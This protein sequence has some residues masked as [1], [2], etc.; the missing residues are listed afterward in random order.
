RDGVIQGHHVVEVVGQFGGGLFE[1][2]IQAAVSFARGVGESLGELS[3]EVFADEWMS[4][5]RLEIGD[6]PDNAAMAANR[7]LRC[8]PR[9][10][11][12][13]VVIGQQAGGAEAL[14]GAVP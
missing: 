14:Y 5:E 11:I 2:L 12:G 8:A 3:G 6:G 10:G 13:G 7:D 9:L 1:V 4:V